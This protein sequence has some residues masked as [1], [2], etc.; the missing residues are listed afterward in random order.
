M[1]AMIS[2]VGLAI[3]MLAVFCVGIAS[4]GEVVRM[5]AKL[6]SETAVFAVGGV[7]RW[8]E[9][10]PQHKKFSVEVEGF[11]PGSE[12]AVLVNGSVVGVLKINEL[13]TGELNYDTRIH[14][15]DEDWQPFPAGFPEIHFG[16]VVAVG[17]MTGTM[18]GR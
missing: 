12:L 9:L 14:P 6:R 8:V 7:A 13:G 18:Q 11:V 5:R 17:R 10:G 16:D 4:A 1:R 2:K 15:G 3:T